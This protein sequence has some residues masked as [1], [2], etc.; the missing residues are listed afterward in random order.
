MRTFWGLL[1]FA[2]VASYLALCVYIGT[3]MNR[4]VPR[5]WLYG[6]LALVAPVVGVIL[7]AIA[8]GSHPVSASA[9]GV[10]RRKIEL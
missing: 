9:S 1:V 3:L 5:G 4:R 7:W 8:R 2:L 10:G 6:V